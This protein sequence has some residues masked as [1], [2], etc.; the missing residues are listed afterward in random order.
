MNN[1][2]DL[3]I[4]LLSSLNGTMLCLAPRPPLDFRT[5]AL[6]LRISLRILRHCL[7]HWL[8]IPWIVSQV[9][10]NFN[11]ADLLNIV[12]HLLC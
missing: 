6:F 12:G 8:A 11:M 5:D 10:L 7:S 1:A 4:T 2:V 3:F 9:L